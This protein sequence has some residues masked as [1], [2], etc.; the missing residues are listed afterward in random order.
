MIQ[1]AHKPAVL[2]TGLSGFVGST[3]RNFCQ[4]KFECQ[5]LD[6]LDPSQPVDITDYDQVIRALTKSD[7]KVVLHL[8][9][10]TD[11]TKAF[12]ES[13]NKDGLAYRVNVLGTKNMA[14][15]ARATGKYLIHVSTAFVFA[16]DKEG[17]YRETDEVS[18][19]EWYGQTKA[20]A[21]EAVQEAGDKASI[22]R[23]DF[24]F[25]NLPF[26]KPDIVRKTVL[27]LEKGYPLFDDHYFGPTY[28]EDLVKI[29]AW[30]ID[31]E[32]QGIYHASS[33]EKWSDFELA[34]TLIELHQLPL[35]VKKGKLDDYLRT[36][37]RPYQRNTAMSSEKLS[38]EIDFELTPIKTAL[39]Q[40]ALG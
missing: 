14:R 33:G 19:I 7:A 34:K 29:F 37:S 2:V 39:S 3:F 8:A 36:L 6:V 40:V 32:P 17:L 12:E 15:A 20:Y 38:L 13:G 9:A 23:I 22:M 28:L 4:G 5:G 1:S 10:F 11:V 35:E 25:R 26:P 21:E 27:G 31:L 16:G 18:P 24:P 30:A